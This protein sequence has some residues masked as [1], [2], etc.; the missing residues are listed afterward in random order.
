MALLNSTTQRLRL[1]RGLASKITTN[2]NAYGAEG[3]PLYTTDTKQLYIHDGNIYAAVPTAPRIVVN[4]DEA[5]S[6]Q[7]ELIWIN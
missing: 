1:L 6:H 3:E 7:D 5:I 4:N 2:N